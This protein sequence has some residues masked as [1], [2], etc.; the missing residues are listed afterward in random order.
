MLIPSPLSLVPRIVRSLLLMLVPLPCL[1]SPRPR[2]IDE[3]LASIFAGAFV[4]LVVRVGLGGAISFETRTTNE[5]IGSK[6]D[7][8]SDPFRLTQFSYHLYA[9]NLNF[10]GHATAGQTPLA[11]ELLGV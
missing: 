10:T 6:K 7:W 4:G 2:L 3:T 11:S 8:D 1:S 9:S 5:I